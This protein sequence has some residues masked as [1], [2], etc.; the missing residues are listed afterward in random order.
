MITLTPYTAGTNS[1]SE[2]RKE[3][4]LSQLRGVP[5]HY[6]AGRPVGNRCLCPECH[7]AERLAEQIES[8]TALLWP[9]VTCDNPLC[10]AVTSWEECTI[11]HGEAE[12]TVLC[13]RCAGQEVR[14]VAA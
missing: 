9:P 13:P 5:D 11:V 14:R 12:S 2:C 6:E 4:P 10:G 1:C 8:D 7:A 3:V